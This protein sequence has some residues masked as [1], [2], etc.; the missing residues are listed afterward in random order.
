M[1]SRFQEIQ[2]LRLSG[3]INGFYRTVK[4]DLARQQTI[5]DLDAR[6]KLH[7]DVRR[8]FTAPGG[9]K[10]FQ[11]SF[12]QTTVWDVTINAT[13]RYDLATAIPLR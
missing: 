1:R 5:L 6:R 13:L 7:A 12:R 10:A 9:I 3:A 4:N 8:A 2:D 11:V